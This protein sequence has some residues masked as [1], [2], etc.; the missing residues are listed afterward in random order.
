M[1]RKKD[2]VETITVKIGRTGSRIEEYALE[3]E[4]PTVGDALEA[5]GISTSKGDKIR[6]DGELVDR[7]TIVEDSA[8][9]MISGKVAGA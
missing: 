6:M 8:I 7:D 9:I 3:G 5:A 2:K 4:E 1:R